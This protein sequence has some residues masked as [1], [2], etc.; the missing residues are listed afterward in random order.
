MHL[1][2]QQDEADDYVVATGEH[3]SVR[4]FTRLA[5]AEAGVTLG[6]EG[7]GADEIGVVDS[8]DA[9]LLSAACNGYGGPGTGHAQAKPGAVVVKVDPRYYRPTEV[10]T[11]LGDA[12]K[13]RERLGWTP[14]HSFHELVSEMVRDDLIQAQRVDVLRAEGFTVQ[15][16]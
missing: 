12:T 16:P 14:S 2:L 6:F 9:D 10:A 4:E 5:F 8:V 1:M 3:H 15:E 11:L 7:A 13:A